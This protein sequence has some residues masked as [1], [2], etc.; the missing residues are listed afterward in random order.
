LRSKSGNSNN[1]ATE[2]PPSIADNDLLHTIASS[3]C[4]K[5][6]KS[7][8]EE[9]GCAVCGEITPVR[10]LSRVKN[11]KNMLHI[12][13]TSGVTRKER[14]NKNDPLHEYSGPVLDYTCN[15]SM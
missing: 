5:M 10:N 8:I 7:N 2:F 12:L 11:I 3:V 15:L 1:L 6:N 13:T 9:A 4:K 14:T